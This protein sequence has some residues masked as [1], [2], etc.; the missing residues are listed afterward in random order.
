MTDHAQYLNRYGFCRWVLRECVRANPLYVISAA[1]LAYGVT[2]LNSEI[3]PQVGKAGGIIAGLSL[4]HAYEIAV[5][6]VAI[7]ILRRRSGGGRDLHGMM[8]VAGLFMG[9]S[10][11]VL[12]ELV[13]IWP[14]L[15]YV[16][17]PATLA[18]ATFKLAVY[19]RL[20]GIALPRSYRGVALLILGAHSVSSL[21]GTQSL[22]MALGL[23]ILQG[24][25]WMDGWASLLSILWL[26]WRESR[27][28]VQVSPGTD[29]LMTRWCGIWFV[30]L[31]AVS[32]LIHLV[33]TD[34]I[35]D[36]TW[37]IENFYAP[38]TVLLS[39]FILL[40]F[41]RAGLADFWIWSLGLLQA[42]GLQWLWQEHSREGC[43]WNAE[44]FFGA[45][46]QACFATLAATLLLVR[47]TGKLEFLYGLA[48]AVGAPSWAWV[49][50][51][52]SMIPHFR[53]FVSSAIGFALLLGGMIVS[54]YRD[55]LLRWLDP[56]RPSAPAN[57][58]D[59]LP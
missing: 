27:V 13:A 6:G 44:L 19:S 26:A 56:A 28:P 51:S 14:W 1:F 53:A 36:R 52:R 37:H 47:Y 15:G 41:Q 2:Q 34:W 54:L 49:S 40:R 50:K 7:F 25:G 43:I 3:D 8:L 39:V 59:S 4:M 17:I 18:L 11:I 9:G 22:K 42:A 31:A 10:F 23:P 12:D 33:A 35:F 29:I 58:S 16:L 24:L 32:G 48:G 5:L 21:L 57:N 55:R 45:A 20:P 30:F 46:N 38:A